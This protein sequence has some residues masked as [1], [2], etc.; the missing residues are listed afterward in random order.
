MKKSVWKSW[1]TALM[2]VGSA[3]SILIILIVALFDGDPAT[4]P[5]WETAVPGILSALGLM[6]AK[7][8]DKTSEE[9]GLGEKAGTVG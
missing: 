7:D 4:V 5:A 9:V 6:A 2:G 3:L 8:G 1:K